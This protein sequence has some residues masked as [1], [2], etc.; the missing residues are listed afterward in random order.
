MPTYEYECRNC[1]HRFEIFQNIKDEHLKSCPKCNK[2]LNRLIGTG[3]GIIFKGSGF[4]ATDYRKK[5]NK[6][7]EDKKEQITCP[8]IKE[9]CR[10]CS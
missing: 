2:T 6:E 10:G 9:G 8:K 7:K 5:P 3:G 1:G 4:Y